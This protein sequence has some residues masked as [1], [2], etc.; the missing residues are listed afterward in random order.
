VQLVGVDGQEYRFAGL[1][2]SVSLAGGNSNRRW[3]V[4]HDDS[5]AAELDLMD[6]AGKKRIILQVPPQ[7]RRASRSS[8][9]T[10]K[11]STN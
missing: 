8:M 5:G 9:P 7:A 3:W 6:T 4:G 11:P 2:V 1:A 10:E